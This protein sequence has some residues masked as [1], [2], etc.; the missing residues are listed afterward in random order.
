M[1]SP[2]EGKRWGSRAV[3]EDC[4]ECLKTPEKKIKLTFLDRRWITF[5]TSKMTGNCQKAE[6]ASQTASENFCQ[7]TRLASQGWLYLA[8][9]SQRTVGTNCEGQHGNNM[10]ILQ[11]EMEQVGSL[12]TQWG[13]SPRFCSLGEKNSKITL[14]HGQH[15]QLL[16]VSS[17]GQ[18]PQP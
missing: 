17:P 10:E 5:L 18:C 11:R 16:G 3:P 4:E 7:N 8:W 1:E 2:P 6:Q 13:S 9:S 15:R 14:P 12:W